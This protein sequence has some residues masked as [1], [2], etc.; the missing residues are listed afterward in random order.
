[1]KQPYPVQQPAAT[2]TQPKPSLPHEHDESSRSQ[3]SASKQHR[4]IGRKAYA[5]ATDGSEDTDR[6]P[7]ADEVYNSKI[8]P[9]RSSGEP[10]R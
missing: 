2:A 1:M 10:R 7:V 6:G 3:A 8:A 4:E 9:D 5:N